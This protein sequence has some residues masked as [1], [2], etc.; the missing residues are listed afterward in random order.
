MKPVLTFL[1][2]FL[3]FF[4][5]KGQSSSQVPALPLSM[6]WNVGF[7]KD[8]TGKPVEWYPATVPG[9]VQLDYARAKKWPDHAYAENWKEYR[10]MEDVYWTYRTEF[11][12]PAL[13]ENERL[14][15]VSRGIDYQ[16]EIHLNGT[17]LFS[18][19]GMF[20]YVNLDITGYLQEDNTLEIL[21]YPVP[22]VPGKP[23]NRDQA[24]QSA[25]P[26]V[27]YGWDWHPRLIP[28]G[29]WD[30]TIL[31]I[32]NNSFLTD[33]YV[34]YDLTEDF[35]KAVI[36]L[37][38]EGS[39]LEG[40]RFQW[41]LKEPSGKTVFDE[42][43]FLPELDTKTFTLSNP[44][45]WWTHDH[46][47]PAL[48]DSEFRILD[49]RGNTLSTDRHKVGFRSIQLVMHDG[50]WSKPDTFPKGRSNPPVTIELN[51]RKIFGKG[52]NWVNPEIFP[53]I[54]TKER[55]KGLLENAVKANF[56]LFRVW[57]GGIINKES[58]YELCDGMGILVWTEFPLA[59]NNYEGSPRYLS[60]LK[61]E[62]EAI[63][64]R[65]RKHPSHAIWCGGN[66]LFNAW[67][68]MTDQSAA[69]RLLNSQCYLLD[70]KTPFL[71]TSPVMGMAHGNYIFKYRDSE[72]E[73]F[74]KMPKSTATAYTEFG[75]PGASDPDLLKKI[76]PEKELF[77]PMPGTSW[78]SHHAFNSWGFDTWLMKDLLASYFGEAG[79][80]E[81]LV[82]QSQWI[83]TEGYRCIFEEARRQKPVCSMALNWCYNEP[84][85]T[86][87]NNSL[88][89]YP[90]IPKPAFYG[91]SSS[92]R[93]FLASA[94]IPKF[95]WR[96]GESFSCEI[97]I[98]ND[99]YENIPSEG[100]MNVKLKASEKESVL[101]TW[102]FGQPK[103]NTN[104]T[105]PTARAIL[106]NWD[107]D[108]FELIVEVE[109]KEQFSS[110]YLLHFQP[111]KRP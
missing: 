39:K 41:T 19:E 43:G 98:L 28:S 48:Y 8:K 82:A 100:V 13:N 75:M 44:Q 107:T 96:P 71:S 5:V 99:L 102:K 87:A 70:P 63:I 46:G 108:R 91:V 25:K 14:F 37:R 80:L 85:I 50:A 101:L 29:I 89:S 109:G 47:I 90:N 60:V 88:I 93:P 66:E 103:P 77:P 18:Q 64:R 12:R 26:A 104:I 33:V 61:E 45:L 106:P 6:H 81:E 27:S 2:T 35:S 74:Q 11:K 105:G 53:G 1:F 49:S 22:K 76:I 20:K 15:F 59:C 78:E 67:S 31:E 9:A 58:F 57:G 4:P 24:A 83:Q 92:C 84:W 54:I 32:R 30:E 69:L 10:W 95:S 51:G 86:A 36:S 68:K 65:I 97:F 16:F 17:P 111:Q 21:I 62:S 55:Y 38:A 40:G 73:V 7:H 56:N 94:R 42:T 23:D 110:S 79:N 72:A 3:L 34:Q 52:S